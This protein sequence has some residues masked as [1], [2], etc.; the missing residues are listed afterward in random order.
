LKGGIH[1]FSLYFKV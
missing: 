1:L